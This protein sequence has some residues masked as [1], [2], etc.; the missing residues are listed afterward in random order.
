MPRVAENMQRGPTWLMLQVQYAR[1]RAMAGGKHAL[2][3]RPE[4]ASGCGILRAGNA[5]RPASSTW[6]NA[7]CGARAKDGLSATA[8][9]GRCSSP[10]AMS[11]D[12][13]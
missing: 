12:Q 7:T 13:R 4:V 6:S 3:A 8:D 2:M 11:S 1:H 10:R 9:G 5:H